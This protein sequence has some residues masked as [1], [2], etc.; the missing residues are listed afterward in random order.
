M[1]L[2][3]CGAG[4]AQVPGLPLEPLNGLNALLLAYIAQVA[5]WCAT[6]EW[7]EL[8]SISAPAG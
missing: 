3:M 1:W 4:L 2:G 5:S 8:R 6:P 7:A